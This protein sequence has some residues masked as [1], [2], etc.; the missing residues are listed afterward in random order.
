MMDKYSTR[1]RLGRLRW[2]RGGGRAGGS[3]ELRRPNRVLGRAREGGVVGPEPRGRAWSVMLVTAVVV[4]AEEE[5][6][7]GA[8]GIIWCRAVV[9]EERSP[10][11]RGPSEPPDSK[12][13]HKRRQPVS[14]WSISRKNR[15]HNRLLSYGHAGRFTP[16]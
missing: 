11:G 7:D 13:G 9:G 2:R 12:I 14:S 15:T 1:W 8:V 5:E 16:S 3:S 10:L 4:T 6:D